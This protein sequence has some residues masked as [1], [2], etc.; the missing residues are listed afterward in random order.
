MK[1]EKLLQQCLDLENQ[2]KFGEII[3]P[4]PFTEDTIKYLLSPVLEF[5]YKSVGK[6]LDHELFIE[7]CNNGD[8]ITAK[9]LCQKFPM[10]LHSK[11]FIKH[12]NPTQIFGSTK[13]LKMACIHGHQDIVHKI[14]KIAPYLKLTSYV[15]LSFYISCKYNQINIV[16]LILDNY[17][18]KIKFNI[19]LAFE[20]VL[21]NGYTEL[22]KL[23]LTKFP[24]SS[25]IDFNL[26]PTNSP[27]SN[28]INYI[29]N[30]IINCHIEFDHHYIVQY[31]DD[32]TNDYSLL[33]NIFA[34]ICCHNN[35]TAA[36]QFKAKWPHVDINEAR[37]CIFPEICKRNYIQMAQWIYQQFPDLAIS[38]H[39]INDALQQTCK[40]GALKM[41][42]WLLEQFATIITIQMK[43][44]AFI[45]AC[46]YNQFITAQWLFDNIPIQSLLVI[47]MAFKNS[48]YAYSNS[49]T[50]SKFGFNKY[51]Q[52]NSDLNIEQADDMDH[53]YIDIEHL[54]DPFEK[55][56]N[57]TNDRLRM[58]KW[59]L[60]KMEFIGNRLPYY[61]FQHACAGGQL[62]IAQWLLEQFPEIKS[63]LFDDNAFLNACQNG[64]LAT[65]KWLIK[66]F[67]DLINKVDYRNI[68]K[69][70]CYNGN[71]ELIKWLLEIFPMIKPGMEEFKISY[72]SGNIKLIQWF[73]TKFSITKD[74]LYNEKYILFNVACKNGYFHLIQWLYDQLY[75]TNILYMEMPYFE[76]FQDLCRN[77]RFNI[78]IWFIKRYYSRGNFQN[79]P[80]FSTI[81]QSKNIKMI[82]W[83]LIKFPK[84]KV[85]SDDHKIAFYDICGSGNL[86]LAK[87]LI[88]IWP[89]IPITS[90][91]LQKIHANAQP[92]ILNWLYKQ[93]PNIF[94]VNIIKQIFKENTFLSLS[95]CKWFKLKWPQLEL[96]LE[97]YKYACQINDLDKLIWQ[98][99]KL[100]NLPT[101]KKTTL[102]MI[103]CHYNSFDIIQWFLQ[104]EQMSDIIDTALYTEAFYKACNQIDTFL[105]QWFMTHYHNLINYSF[106]RTFNIL[107]AACA[108]RLYCMLEWC[109]EYIPITPKMIEQLLIKCTSHQNY[110]N[111]PRYK[112][113]SNEP[114]YIILQQAWLTYMNKS[115]RDQIQYLYICSLGYPE[116]TNQIF[117][118]NKHTSN[119]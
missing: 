23:L 107:E 75:Q 7:V 73:L 47:N 55:Y 116:L 50:M 17:L 31:L 34:R 54:Y 9:W 65:A 68:F 6:R 67:P 57:I 92:H 43:H 112:N 58:I 111:L 81:C 83:F 45:H 33:N 24:I 36:K 12:V 108:K 76:I 40:V 22:A 115:D 14:L 77:N 18:N 106:Q 28:A 88:K 102:F 52:I 61:A 86:R 53:D 72:S 10:L 42:Q 69:Q 60:S 8:S 103:A 119:S 32:Y 27:T 95:I 26:Q 16:K 64:Q 11:L 101:N 44:N 4:L 114:F 105:A 35:L 90:D 46:V 79:R 89:N 80:I 91:L 74:Q 29:S 84:Y 78:M 85:Y 15:N 97:H 109:L 3:Q 59:L 70:T 37:V 21:G 66:V 39:I 82:K 2:Y 98:S 19:H 48:C 96:T 117:N 100:F 104:Q 56:H 13:F 71:L 99:D 25:Q 63:R 62:Y 20:M 94:D 87:W 93:F 110:F 113:I 5:L 41:V 51:E 1:L 30:N 38:C 118:K 49:P